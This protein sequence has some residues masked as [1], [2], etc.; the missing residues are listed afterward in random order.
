MTT[1]GLVASDEL[2]TV[3]LDPKISSGDKNTVKLQIGFSDDWDG[4]AKTAVFFTES[5]KNTVYEKVITTGECIVPAEVMKNSGVIY[6]GIRG[7]NADKIEVKTTS[8]VKYTII[9]GTPSAEEVEPTDSLCQQLL[10]AYGRIDTAIMNETSERKFDK[11]EMLKLI[12]N[13]DSKIDRENTK[14]LGVVNDTKGEIL[15]KLNTEKGERQAAINRQSARIDNFIALE[16]GSTTGDAELKD[17]R[18]GSDG[19][20]YSSAGTAVRSQI[21]KLDTTISQQ[22]DTLTTNLTQKINT[23]NTNLTQKIN[24]VN[25]E[26]SEVNNELTA[27]NTQLS[28]IHIQSFGGSATFDRNGVLVQSH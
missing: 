17:I 13:M 28:D 18:I 23:V 9:E 14:T 27:V 25:G 21:K 6:I 10:T 26:I 3:V 15:S 19:T 11:A 24:T 7:V 12:D 8:L 16:D 20:K 2:L 4:F 1:I 5:D 22:A